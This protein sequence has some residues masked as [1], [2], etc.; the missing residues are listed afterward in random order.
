MLK[1]CSNEHKYSNWDITKN[2][3]S[4]E[5]AHTRTHKQKHKTPKPIRGADVRISKEMSKKNTDIRPSL[6]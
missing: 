2:T 4:E 3:K 6:Q 5:D 1:P